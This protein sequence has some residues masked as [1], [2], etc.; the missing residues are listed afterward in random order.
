MH[1]GGGAIRNDLGDLLRKI[2]KLCVRG[3]YM[4][5][6]INNEEGCTLFWAADKPCLLY[7]SDA[8]DE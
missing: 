3:S 2:F 8:A 6:T 4:V 1:M 5:P 7:T